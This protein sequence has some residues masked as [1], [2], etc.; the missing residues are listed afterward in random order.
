MLPL[1]EPVAC[2]EY[3]RSRVILCLFG[4]LLSQFSQELGWV[5][6]DAD[7]LGVSEGPWGV[8]AFRDGVVF[9]V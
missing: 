2:F 9:R 4:Y 8:E 6:V 5:R 7:G 3:E 1:L